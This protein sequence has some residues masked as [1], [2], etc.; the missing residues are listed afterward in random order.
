[1][2]K[3][4]RRNGYITIKAVHVWMPFIFQLVVLLGGWFSLQQRV[5]DMRSTIDHM[6]SEIIELRA[7]LYR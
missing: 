5:D 2:V 6:Q 3:D 1:M 4:D 7:H